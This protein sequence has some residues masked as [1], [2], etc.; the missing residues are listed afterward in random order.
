MLLLLLLLAL[1]LFL[2]LL[3][4]L[5]STFNSR[6]AIYLFSLHSHPD[7]GLLS[8]LQEGLQSDSLKLPPSLVDDLANLPELCSAL[9]KSFEGAVPLDVAVRRR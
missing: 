7:G 9:L 8:V 2:N 4:L 5:S 6:E 1:I 3:L